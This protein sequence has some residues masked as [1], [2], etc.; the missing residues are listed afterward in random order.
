M[1]LLNLSQKEIYIM[2]HVARQIAIHCDEPET[3][4]CPECASSMIESDWSGDDY[5]L[6]CDDSD[7]GYVIDEDG[8][9]L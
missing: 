1:G 7:C 2:C 5:W 8:D 6:K 3:I 4:E 9:E